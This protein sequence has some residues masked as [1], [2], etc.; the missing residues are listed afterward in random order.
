MKAAVRPDHRGWRTASGEDPDADLTN[1]HDAA[2]TFV[3]ADGWGHSPQF[4]VL[5]V[6]EPATPVG[7]GVVAVRSGEDGPD[8]LF[9]WSSV[10]AFEAASAAARR[11][12]GPERGGSGLAMRLLPPTRMSPNDQQEFR[13]LGLEPIDLGGSP[14]VPLLAGLHADGRQRVITPAHLFLVT[15]LMEALALMIGR[16]KIDGDGWHAPMDFTGSAGGK[17]IRFRFR[18]LDEPQDRP[19]PAPSGEDARASPPPAA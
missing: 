7:M 2:Q 16:A 19:P 6:V 9:F 11:G 17:T 14:V 3:A 10:E 18:P 4:L 13:R 15:R 1:F 5:E 8:G 12:A